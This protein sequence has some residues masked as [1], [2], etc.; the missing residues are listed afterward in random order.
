MRRLRGVDR[1][2]SGLVIVNYSLNP[3]A[4]MSSTPALRKKNVNVNLF[5][6]R[7]KPLL[8][9]AAQPMV[10]GGRRWCCPTL[11]VFIHNISRTNLGE[12]VKNNHPE[13]YRTVVILGI[14]RPLCQTILLLL[15]ILF[16]VYSVHTNLEPTY[17]VE[18]YQ[19]LIFAL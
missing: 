6:V 15:F 18:S 3:A 14:L 12:N 19:S 17:F 4:K 11:A 1:I 16:Y 7:E 10:G 2:R 8:R 9:A 13:R 5:I